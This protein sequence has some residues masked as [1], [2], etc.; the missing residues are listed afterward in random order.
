MKRSED[1]VAM[2]DQ[3]RYPW[4]SDPAF[5]F[6][7]SYL[8]YDGTTTSL[9][10]GSQ[11]RSDFDGERGEGDRSGEGEGDR[12]AGKKTAKA[13]WLA[14]YPLLGFAKRMVG[15]HSDLFSSYVLILILCSI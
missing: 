11:K 6:K 2:A 15:H 7:E 10:I 3:I 1:F 14:T 5:N 9:L 13:T 8:A 4:R 12:R